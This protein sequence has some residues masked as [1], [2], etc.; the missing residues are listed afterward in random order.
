MNLTEFLK[1]RELYTEDPENGNIHPKEGFVFQVGQFKFQREIESK[2]NGGYCNWYGRCN[3]YKYTIKETDEIEIIVDPLLIDCSVRITTN[4]TDKWY[5]HGS[6]KKEA[7]AVIDDS[8]D[9]T[10]IEFLYNKFHA[11]DI[12]YSY[13]RSTITFKIHLLCVFEERMFNLIEF[14]LI[15]QEQFII[16]LKNN[17]G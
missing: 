9:E 4:H 7:L 6:D 5:I 10:V 3:D 11:T 16:W 8:M 15:T 12:D 13:S 1:H 14:G 2:S 17:Y